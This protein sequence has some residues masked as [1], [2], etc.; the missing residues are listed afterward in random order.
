M[1]FSS[2][3]AGP[4]TNSTWRGLRRSPESTSLWVS[5]FSWPSSPKKTSGKL[6]GFKGSSKGS[7]SI[8]IN[9]FKQT[10]E[11]NTSSSCPLCSSPPRPSRSYGPKCSLSVP[12]SLSI[13][14]PRWRPLHLWPRNRP[15]FPSPGC[16][17]SLSVLL[18]PWILYVR[19]ELC[20]RPCFWS[21]P[22]RFRTVWDSIPGPFCLCWGGISWSLQ[23]T[24]FPESSSFLFSV[25]CECPERSF[26]SFGEE[27]WG[28]EYRSF[29]D[30]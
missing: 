26:L 6:S 11:W 7:S 19:R 21:E 8:V 24:A 4:K 30:A 18:V 25:P 28:F 23:S 2:T 29:W 16:N 3:T 14:G 13:P 12:G 22:K 10:A 1:S 9:S 5:W 15:H 17:I 20:L 27:E